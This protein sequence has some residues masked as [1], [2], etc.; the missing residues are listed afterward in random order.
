MYFNC[1]TSKYAFLSTILCGAG[2]SLAC[3]THCEFGHVAAI[4]WLERCP[5]ASGLETDGFT[6][7]EYATI[8][9]TYMYK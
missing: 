8:S 4:W 2:N 3:L 6:E 1:Y 5:M 9:Y 7:C